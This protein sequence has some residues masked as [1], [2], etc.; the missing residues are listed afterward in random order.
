MPGYAHLLDKA[1]NEAG[2]KASLSQII[3]HLLVAF[4]S[5]F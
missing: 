5:K 3:D 2:S 1:I 4:V